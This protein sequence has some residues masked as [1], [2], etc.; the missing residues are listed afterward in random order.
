M[1]NPALVA[2]YA[3]SSVSSPKVTFWPFWPFFLYT[4]EDAKISD[5]ILAQFVVTEVAFVI[6][7]EA[8]V[9]A[10]ECSRGLSWPV[11]YA[12]VVFLSCLAPLRGAKT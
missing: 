6:S 8:K 12:G 10:C 1:R 4:P 2:L 11:L 7:E 5:K 3:G 9:R